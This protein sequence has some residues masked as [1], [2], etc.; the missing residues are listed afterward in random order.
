MRYFV[1]ASMALLVATSTF[2]GALNTTDVE[3]EAIVRSAALQETDGVLCRRMEVTGSHI[4]RRICRTRS[5][6][7]EISRQ[8]EELQRRLP[9]GIAEFGWSPGPDTR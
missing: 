8:W 7:E 4:K 9:Q 1:F 5:E 2:A 3:T 6:W